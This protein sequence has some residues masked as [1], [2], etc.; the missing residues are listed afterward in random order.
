MMMPVFDTTVVSKAKRV[1]RLIIPAWTRVED[2]PF[3]NA[4]RS[5]MDGLIFFHI[6]ERLTEDPSAFDYL[7][8]EMAEGEKR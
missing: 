8:P 7:L 5:L 4:A 3:D 2:R 1:L 6:A